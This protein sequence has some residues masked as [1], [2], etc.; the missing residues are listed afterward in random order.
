MKSLFAFNSLNKKLLVIFLS[1]TMLPL[2][3]IIG[4]IYL[5]TEQGFT[6]MMTAQQE[7]LEHAVQS[8]LSKVSDDL[9]ALTSLYADNEE[10]IAAYESGDRQQLIEVVHQLYPR[11]QA[12]HD[13]KVFELGGSS[14]T[15]YLRAHNPEKFGDDKSEINAIQSAL[16]GQSFSGFEFG[17]SGLSVRSFAPI[18]KGNQV[19]GTLQTGIDDTFLHELNEM[20]QG[21]TIDLYN[22]DGIIMESS[23][24]ENMGKSIEDQTLMDK[25]AEGQS[26]SKSNGT[27]LISYMPMY[28]PTQQNVIG[29][30]GIEQD[31]SIVHHTKEQIVW[32]GLLLTLATFIL[33]LAVSIL[34][35]RSLSKPIK[36]TANWMGELAAGNLKIE[37]QKSRR[38]DEIGTLTEAIQMMK[39]TLHDTMQQVAS[40]SFHVAEQSEELA[41]AA[42]EVKSGSDQIAMTMQEI[43]IGSEKQ[44][45]QIGGLAD[46]MNQF[47]INMQEVTEKG[48]QIQQTSAGVQEMTHAGQQLMESSAKQMMTIDK[49]VQEAVKKMNNLDGQTQEISKLVTVI[50]EVAD[51]TNLL[52]LNAAIEASRAGEHGKGFAVVADEVRKLAEQVSVSVTDITG[53]VNGIQAESADVT[54]S[55]EIG[56]R[57]VAQGTQHITE[58][59]KTFNEINDAIDNMSGLIR[60]ITEHLA[61]FSIQSEQL[62]HAVEEIASISEEAASGVEETAATSQQS[63]SSMEEVAVGADKLSS[64]AE[65]LNRLVQRFTL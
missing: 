52:A 51:Q 23:N 44:A 38:Q 48:E 4:G 28:E 11:L 6:K 35:S 7:E 47:S 31:L 34:F 1:V 36:Q 18:T 61:D 21:A 2:A 55:L 50:Q 43:A 25:V 64:L 45:D 5:A 26:V 10:L 15:V 3:L 62:N 33:V 53:I 59:T 56:Y 14:G 65:E 63:S 13:L 12:E 27:N 9:L 40:A 41:H 39:D 49:V 54:Q 20:F 19:I 30:I 32:I 58:T 37:I 17:S 22:G 60:M 8:Q 16:D 57:E 42:N 24:D 46:T 29:M